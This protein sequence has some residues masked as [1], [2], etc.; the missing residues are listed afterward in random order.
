MNSEAE[1][2]EILRTGSTSKNARAI[3]TPQWSIFASVAGLCASVLVVALYA[4]GAISRFPAAYLLAV[5]LSVMTIC[6][7]AGNLL[8]LVRREVPSNR[9]SLRWSSVSYLG[10]MAFLFLSTV[11]LGVGTYVSYG[12]GV[13]GVSAT[14]GTGLSFLYVAQITSIS[15]TNAL[16]TKVTLGLLLGVAYSVAVLL[17]DSGSTGMADIAVH[18]SLLG[19]T[20]L[21]MSLLSNTIHDEI[22]RRSE[23]AD[24]LAVK[25]NLWSE[26]AR[27][28][29]L[30]AE[31]EDP[32]QIQRAVVDATVALGYEVSAITILD[33][34]S[35]TFRYVHP[36]AAMPEE[37]LNKTI[38]VSGISHLV[39][40]E[41]NTQVIDYRRYDHPIPSLL[42]LGIRT[43]VGIP[44]WNGG[45]IV[46]VLIAGSLSTREILA[47]ELT[48]LELLAAAGSSALEHR[49]VT[50]DLMSQLAQYN[51]MIEN[52][53]NPTIVLDEKEN[54][55]FSNKKADLFLGYERQD[56]L[57]MKP[58]DFLQTWQEIN[59]LDDRGSVQFQTVAT[60]SDGSEV[61]VEVTGSRGNSQSERR[62]LTM[63]IRDIT[64][65]RELEAK[66]L[67]LGRLDPL[68]GLANR[69]H[70]IDET[71]RAVIR[72]SRTGARLALVVFE[73][74]DCR[75][76]GSPSSLENEKILLS[77]VRKV[78]VY[79][80]EADLLARI[81]EHRFAV[82]VE[83]LSEAGTLSYTQQLLNVTTGPFFLED[84][85]VRVS[86][87]FGVAFAGPNI[88]ASALLQRANHALLKGLASDGSNITFFEPELKSVAWRRLQIESDLSHALEDRQ[89]RLE[90]QPI[91][92]LRTQ[93]V[94][95]AE[96]LLRWEHPSRGLIPPD[97]YIAIAEETGMIVP[98]GSWVIREASQQIARW[99]LENALGGNF[100]IHVNVSRVQLNSEDIVSEI[101][102]ALDEF[103]LDPNRL[104]IELT[105]SAF[106]NDFES[107]I[108]ILKKIS[109][110]GVCLAIDDFGTGYSSLG[111]LTTLPVDI[112]KIDKSFV[113]QLG[114]KT[115]LIEMIIAMAKRLDVATV[116][117][118]IE[119]T[120]QLRRLQELGCQF[121]QG[122]LFGGA[123]RAEAFPGFLQR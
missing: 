79:A 23:L 61:D 78:Q 43:T 38:P 101:A 56:L 73:L 122:Y 65:Q 62:L 32:S 30:L 15:T 82:L 76:G 91:V 47:E 2:E 83:G 59:N 11:L 69:S 6:S 4:G 5:S 85:E 75:D 81:G 50:A 90:Y 25:A 99:M 104:S 9:S 95:A 97:E 80:R 112:L 55:V 64:R 93:R 86:A 12:S 46:A 71:R 57:E 42:E 63:T 35:G 58:S 115:E 103:D 70:L 106:S 49:Y 21:V 14:I 109:E 1:T 19:I 22:A 108:K 3:A 94:E 13:V 16:R 7:A 68:T 110:L 18:L 84:R 60:C 77:I 26:I 67:D 48:A 36:S 87:N 98:I 27:R 24:S 113:N 120:G 118:G 10:A 8:A 121:G 52:S 116:A 34:Q 31:M 100:S 111:M 102:T 53:P 29:H 20:G 123:V 37:L 17:R 105:E 54:I 44:M 40:R 51:S 119:L 88:G 96:A 33:R 74:T 28:A 107:A 92:N 66:L 45:E 117:E 114:N 39:L 41:R 89:F 72:H